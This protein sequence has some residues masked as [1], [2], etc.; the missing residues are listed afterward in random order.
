MKN[1]Y[2]KHNVIMILCF[3]LG[4]FTILLSIISTYSVFWEFN[5]LERGFVPPPSNFTQPNNFTP[6]NFNRSIERAALRSPANALTSP[7]FFILLFNGIVLLSGG[8]SIWRLTRDKEM[9]SEKEK[10]TSLLLLPEERLIIHELK[11]SRGSLTQSQL[12]KN[13]GMSKV[14]THRIVNRLASKGII[15]KYPYGLTNKIVLEKDV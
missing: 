6:P 7:S 14:K 11:K 2:K 1:E 12:V 13:T 9:K 5:T 15:K 8:I 10:L 4:G 3:I